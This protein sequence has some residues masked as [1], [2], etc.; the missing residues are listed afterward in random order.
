MSSAPLAERA[1][2]P[3]G[4]PLQR[5]GT[6][7]LKGARGQ[8]REEKF[9]LLL[10]GSW[11]LGRRELQK[12]V[13]GTR[14]KMP[15]TRQGTGNSS[16]ERYPPAGSQGR[17]CTM[18]GRKWEPRLMGEGWQWGQERGLIKAPG[19]RAKPTPTVRTAALEKLVPR[20]PA[21]LW[22]LL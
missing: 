20:V 13:G 15:T 18:R 14:R 21:L 12:T 6:G 2:C 1:P 11:F 3:A 17:C 4:D 7:L 22:C 5:R 10:T 16:K 19:L 9:H 8:E